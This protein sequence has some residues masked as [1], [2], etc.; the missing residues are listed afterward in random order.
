MIV[1]KTPSKSVES[2]WHPAPSHFCR[3]SAVAHFFMYGLP[4]SSFRYTEN[5]HLILLYQ[6]GGQPDKQL[7]ARMDDTPDRMREARNVCRSFN[8]CP[9]PSSVP[10][11]LAICPHCSTNQ[12]NTPATLSGSFCAASVPCTL[13]TFYIFFQNHFYQWPLQLVAYIL[14]QQY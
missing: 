1:G 3:S 6:I 14:R 13:C 9:P 4:Y 8:V 10:R 5:L 2:V 12:S 7:R 11:P